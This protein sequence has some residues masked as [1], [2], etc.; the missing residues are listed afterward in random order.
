M[1]VILLKHRR[2]LGKIGEVVTVKDGFGRNYLIPQGMALRATGA[3]LE[4]INSQKE[5]LEKQNATAQKA[6][7]ASRAKLTGKDF[8]FIKQCA[9]DGKLFGSVS[10][11]DIAYILADKTGMEIIHSNI[12]LQHPIKSIGI[13]E[14]QISLH[15][16]VECDI[17]INIAR[18]ESEAQDALTEYKSSGQVS[19]N[20]G[21][22]AA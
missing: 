22:S 2:R 14:V 11:K 1:K 20:E 10:A 16:D 18:S 4:L 19:A 7:V 13:Y 12:F 21:A 8:T 5:D 9:D 15:A 6:A 3:N 17:L